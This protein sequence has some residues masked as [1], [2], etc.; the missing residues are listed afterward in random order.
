MY[1]PK[2]L[3]SKPDDDSDGEGYHFVAVYASIASLIWYV[4]SFRMAHK[5]GLQQSMMDVVH[6]VGSNTG[7]LN[8]YNVRCC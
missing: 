8:L 5:V 4:Y 6:E 7:N 2:V 1:E 3:A